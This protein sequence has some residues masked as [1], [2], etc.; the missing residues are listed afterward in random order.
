M[1]KALN[2]VKILL[3]QL[4]VS[5]IGLLF[6]VVAWRSYFPRRDNENMFYLCVC[7]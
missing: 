5:T 2:E 7:I 4:L 6:F 1:S 3:R